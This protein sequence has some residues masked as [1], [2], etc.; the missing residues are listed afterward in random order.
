MIKSMLICQVL[1]RSKENRSFR[2]S[3]TKNTKRTRSNAMPVIRMYECALDVIIRYWEKIEPSSH[4]V[5]ASIFV[6][7]KQ[8]DRIPDEVQ[9]LIWN[10]IFPKHR[11]K[12]PGIK[13]FNRVLESLP[14]L[15]AA[16]MPSLSVHRR[17]VTF[18]YI[19]PRPLA[20][21]ESLRKR[22]IKVTRMLEDGE[23]NMR[24][25]LVTER[26]VR[27]GAEHLDWI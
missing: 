18:F 1:L 14:P 22:I 3:S 5:G 15:R 6:M 21:E 25:S 4:T 16:L 17:Y 8:M 23:R 20:T 9:M 13:K 7:K 24:A 27:F 19:A 26:A 11:W 2:R 12:H 10:Y